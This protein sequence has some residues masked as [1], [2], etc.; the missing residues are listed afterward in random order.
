MS[1][2]RTRDSKGFSV[3]PHESSLSDNTLVRQ[4][5][6]TKFYLDETLLRIGGGRRDDENLCTVWERGLRVIRFTSQGTL[7]K[8]VRS[9]STLSSFDEEDGTDEGLIVS[10]DPTV[11]KQSVPKR[12][13]N[14]VTIKTSGVQAP[15]HSR[16]LRP[17]LA[18]STET[19]ML[20]SLRIPPEVSG[21]WI[22][23]LG[24]E[25]WCLS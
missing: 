18:K 7:V 8:R 14:T 24:E 23:I 5:R 22:P 3:V 6:H 15:P 10:Y 19:T 25:M 13:S 12:P 21:P 9:T 16:R 11:D 20:P 4:A 17:S 1:H 2:K